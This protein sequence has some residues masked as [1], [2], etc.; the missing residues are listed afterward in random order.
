VNGAGANKYIELIG[1]FT[2]FSVLPEPSTLALVGFGCAL[3]LRA[4]GRV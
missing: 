1:D 3:L 4:R 2:Q